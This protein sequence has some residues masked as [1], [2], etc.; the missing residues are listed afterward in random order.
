MKLAPN[1]QKQ[2]PALS[3]KDK[4]KDVYTKLQNSDMANRVNQMMIQRLM[5]NDKKMQQDLSA[6][7][8]QLID[9]QYRF[10][11]LLKITNVDTQQLAELV[12]D[13]RLQDFNKA[14]DK[15]DAELG[16]QIIDTVEDE[17]NIVII[18][19]TVAGSPDDGFFRSKFKLADTGKPELIQGLLG[20]QVG[21]KV[22]V[23]LNQKLHTVE[24]LGI[25]K[26]I[27]KEVEQKAD[28][29][30]LSQ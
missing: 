7:L 18:T 21:A 6:A 9:L 17:D 2:E 12:N 26:P 10:Q 11:A 1:G 23:M 20:K 28:S 15:E 14:S 27:K 13:A 22:D 3:T 30:T 29:E 19:S 4:F 5:E 25:R 8:S 16:Y 24:L